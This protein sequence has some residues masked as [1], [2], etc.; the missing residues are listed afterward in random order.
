MLSARSRRLQAC[1]R[2]A[3]VVAAGALVL[4]IASAGTASA[5][6]RIAL[7]VH[8]GF[9]VPTFDIADV[10][11]AGP[12]FGAGLAF[13]LAPKVWLMGEADFGSHDGAEI[14]PGVDGPDVD[15]YHFMGKLGYT[16]YTSANGKW[17]LLLNAGAGM[18]SF[19]VDAAAPTKRYFA[20]NAGAKLSYALSPNLD[21]VVS[22]QGDIAFTDKSVFGAS[23]A[24]IWPV[25][26]G[27]RIRL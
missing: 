25:S 16:V 23:T 6:G 3:A 26:A 10:A 12:S 18:M 22:P 15:V 27:I 9:N 24:W 11:K 1:L 13:Q 21:F 2:P 5:Q 14:T 19:D 7:E 4:S 8:G 17:S 20:I